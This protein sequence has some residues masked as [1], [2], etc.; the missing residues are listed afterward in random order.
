MSE[1]EIRRA[2]AENDLFCRDRVAIAQPPDH[3][4]AR[5]CVV[6]ERHGEKRLCLINPAEGGPL[7]AAEDLH[8]HGR[9]SAIVL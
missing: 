6:L 1:A 9:I 7:L 2:D 4:A 5:R 8:R 3:R